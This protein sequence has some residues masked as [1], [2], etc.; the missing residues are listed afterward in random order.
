MRSAVTVCSETDA[1]IT[2]MGKATESLLTERDTIY[3]YRRNTLNT[4]IKTAQPDSTLK[5]EL[6]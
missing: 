4:Q 1:A 6:V 5:P 3:A 2:F